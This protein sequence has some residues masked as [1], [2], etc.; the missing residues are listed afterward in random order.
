VHCPPRVPVQVMKIVLPWILVIGLGAGLGA[1]FV[2]GNAKDRELAALREEHQQA[3]AARAELDEARSQA[4]A[5]SNELAELRQDKVDLLKLRNEVGQL[6]GA[7]QQLSSQAQ[8]A[9][10][11]ADRA[12]AQAAQ[13][14]KNGQANAQKLAALQTEMELKQRAAAAGG[15]PNALNACLNNLRQIDAAKQQWALEHGKSAYIVPTAQDLIPYLGL[16][17]NALPACPAG[18]TYT[19]N[20]VG[21]LPTCTIPGHALPK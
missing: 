7:N 16:R 15:P 9:K 21:Q 18:G 6:R 14:M 5:Q 11:E 10:S 17:A 4:A 2:S 19:L 20:S 3:E 13:A 1:L 8:N 12:Q